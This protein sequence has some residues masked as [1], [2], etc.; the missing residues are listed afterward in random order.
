MVRVTT[1]IWSRGG[2][3]WLVE[4]YDVAESTPIAAEC[5]VSTYTQAMD[6]KIEAVE[7]LPQA[8]VDRL[9][10]KPG[11]VR[12]RAHGYAQGIDRAVA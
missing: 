4:L 3:Q 7:R 12:K 6:Q 10:L 8:V 11:E 5:A 9:R 1:C 2:S